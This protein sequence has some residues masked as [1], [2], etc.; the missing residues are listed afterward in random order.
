MVKNY[1]PNA[2][3]QVILLSTDTEIGASLLQELLPNLSHTV[4][5]DFDDTTESTTV[6]VN[7][8]FEGML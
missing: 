4:S 8:Y 1:F 5:L 6:E 3:N 7:K 2:S